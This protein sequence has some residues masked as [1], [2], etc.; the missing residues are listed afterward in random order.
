MEYGQNIHGKYYLELDNT[1][2]VLAINVRFLGGEVNGLADAE[3]DCLLRLTGGTR[4]TW[5]Q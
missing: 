2:D 3:G 4:V 5:D 1:L